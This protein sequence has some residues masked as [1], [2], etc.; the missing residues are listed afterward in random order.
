MKPR[1]LTTGQAAKFCGVTPDAVL[2][3]IRK[4]R[5][6]A[7]RTAGGHFRISPANLDALGYEKGNP[8]DEALGKSFQSASVPRHCWEYFC[9]STSPSE[10]CKK[11]VVYRARIEKCYEV[12][13]LGDAIGHEGRFCQ[14]TCENCSFFRA[15][16][17]LATTVLVVTSDEAL[18][19]RLTA[20]AESADV[21][22]R[23]ARGGYESSI[24]IGTFHPSVAVMDSAMPEVRDGRLVDSMMQDKRIPGMRII[25]ALRNG[26]EVPPRRDTSVMPAPFTVK[27]IERLVQ[28]IVRPIIQDSIAS[29]D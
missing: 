29:Q 5:L 22:L 11:C 9:R 15:C 1:L 18:I 17:G 24:L 8:C 27:K 23:F 19:G 6:A 7:V 21:A 4:G 14:A 16:K 10:T 25:I 26:D 2:K 20:Q 13:G 12:A 3:W 28:A